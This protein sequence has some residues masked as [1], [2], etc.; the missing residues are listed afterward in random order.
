MTKESPL[1]KE[2][3]RV[4][5]EME[6]ADPET[7]EYQFVAGNLR[8]LMEIEALE[9]KTERESA[10]EPVLPEPK[11]TVSPDTILLVAGNLLGILAVLNYERVHVVTSK[12]LGFIL[13]PR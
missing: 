10:P 3:H 9:A 8:T 13:K 7:K 4:L 6:T 12:A 1:R 5:Q 11:K 2:I